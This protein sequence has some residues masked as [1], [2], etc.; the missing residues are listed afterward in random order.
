MCQAPG[1]C[2]ADLLP[3]KAWPA[4]DPDPGLQL[5]APHFQR[6]LVCPSQKQLPCSLP[7][8]GAALTS[9]PWSHP[10]PQGP[11]QG[12]QE[13]GDKQAGTG[14]SGSNTTVQYHPTSTGRGKGWLRPGHHQNDLTSHSVYPSSMQ[15]LL[16]EALH[17]PG[18]G[19]PFSAP[20]PTA[21]Q[22]PSALGLAVW[23]LRPRTP[24]RAWPMSTGPRVCTGSLVLGHSPCHSA[25]LRP[26]Q[27]A[28]Q[29][30]ARCEVRRPK[31]GSCG[32]EPSMSTGVL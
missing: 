5:G 8:K 14:V 17:P 20:S 26:P 15:H 7:G 31:P 6:D 4:P 13:G 21:G 22:E 19:W 18:Q 24:G 27:M 29:P 2:G 9:T 25:H 1:H 23:T 16:Q 3:L 10:H 11:F 32:L 30:L 12:S 28:L